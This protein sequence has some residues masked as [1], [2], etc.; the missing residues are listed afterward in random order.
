MT[1]IETTRSTG[2]EDQIKERVK[3]QAGRRG[4]DALT[5]SHRIHAH[6]ELAFEEH[7]AAGWLGDLLE[8]QGFAVQIGVAGLETALVA[9]LGSGELVVGIC[10]EYDALPQ[11][12]HAC[13]HNVIAAS[14]ALAGMALASE[15]DALGLTLKIFGTPAEERGGGKVIMLRE[16]VFDGLHA[17]MMVHPTPHDLIRPT[18]TA[19]AQVDVEFLGETPQAMSPE[20][21]RDAGAAATLL[22][23]AVGL[24]RQSIRSTDRISGVVRSAGHSPNVLPDRAEL[25]YSLRAVTDDRLSELV[26]QFRRCAEGAALATGTQVRVT[27]PHPRYAALRHHERLGELY[28]AN[29]ERLGR[30]F[31]FVGTAD[32]E[33]S[34]ATDF[35]N[36]SSIVPAIHPL[37]GVDAEGASNHQAHFARHCGLA[38]GDAAVLDAGLA[39]AWTVVDISTDPGLRRELL[40]HPGGSR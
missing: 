22:Q 38:S 29:A 4:D 31:H 39:M 6:P 19:L 36:L 18:I 21:G 3:G 7:Q 34:A 17:A 15:L 25:T 11:V 13:G 14:A 27:E 33:R 28:Q 9:S 1:P 24:L 16:G 37:V 30:E 23:V 8:R 32:T 10:A 26:E 12:G 40:S 20:L 35:G 5:L 2:P